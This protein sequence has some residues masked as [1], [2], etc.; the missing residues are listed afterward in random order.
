MKYP[1]S[2][3]YLE[4]LAPIWKGVMTLCVGLFAVENL[5]DW[6]FYLFLYIVFCVGSSITLSPADVK[7]AGRG[8]AAFTA[9]IFLLNLAT[10]WIIGNN[11]I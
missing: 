1:A 10:L 8:F 5:T 7:G 11:L 6:R 3:Y 4:A 2:E 9:V